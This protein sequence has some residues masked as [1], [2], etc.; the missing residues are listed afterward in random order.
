VAPYHLVHYKIV[1][2]RTYQALAPETVLTA[3]NRQT[4]ESHTPR[5]VNPRGGILTLR[6]AVD[7]NY[8]GAPEVIRRTAT[9]LLERLNSGMRVI[10]DQSH[11]GP[12]GTE[13]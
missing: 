8:A 12:L 7:A 6:H 9:A 10:I 5:L 11:T 2:A 3:V 13:N 1:L 4:G